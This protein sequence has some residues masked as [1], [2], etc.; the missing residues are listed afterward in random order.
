[1]E[2][3]KDGEQQAGAPKAGDIWRSPS[4]GMEFLYAPAG[5]F[6]MGSESREAYL[7]E[8]PVHRVRITRGFWLGKYPVTQAQWEAVMGSN[9]SHFKGPDRPV[10]RVSWDEAQEF[11]KKLSAKGEGRYRLPTE[12]EWEYAARAGSTGDR[13]SEALE[14]I[15]W[16]HGNSGGETHPVG[17]KKPNAWGLYD[18]LGNVCEWCQDWYGEYLK[19]PVTDPKGPKSG[20]SRV[21]RGGSW[22]NSP[23]CLRA[24]LR[25]RNDPGSRS[26]YLGFRCVREE[27]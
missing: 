18:M 4:T 14:E 25:D 20:A 21:L 13:Y 7:D 22:V 24:S 23:W 16:Y 8:K 3:P 9:P 11:L 1:V 12:A 26:V 10:E 17:R 2:E 15:G 5:E 6:D 27:E 19:G